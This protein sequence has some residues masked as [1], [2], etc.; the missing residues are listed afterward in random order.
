MIY[1]AAP[2]C[3]AAYEQFKPPPA[4]T[5]RT[6]RASEIGLSLGECAHFNFIISLA[7]WL[8]RPPLESKLIPNRKLLLAFQPSRLWSFDAAGRGIK[9]INF[10]A[11][12]LSVKFRPAAAGKSCG[13]HIYT[14][15]PLDFIYVCI[16]FRRV[17]QQKEQKI[18]SISS[19]LNP[20]GWADA[21]AAFEMSRE[22]LNAMRCGLA[23]Y[24]RR[25]NNPN[26]HPAGH[27]TT[28]TRLKHNLCAVETRLLCIWIIHGAARGD[29]LHQAEKLDFGPA[30][31]PVTQ[32]QG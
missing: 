7:G 14:L 26:H 5:I 22:D 2:G 23:V 30:S 18:N 24:T 17:P 9:V 3:I 21:D 19:Q 12:K 31:Q 16:S 11:K 1:S 15:I 8:R 28:N 29:V 4:L 10:H 6:P 25:R 20:E 32:P 27:I 13:A